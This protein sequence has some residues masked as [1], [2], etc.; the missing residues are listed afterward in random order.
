MSGNLLKLVEKSRKNLG[1]VSVLKSG[2]LESYDDD[3]LIEI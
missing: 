3:L 2:N 1:I